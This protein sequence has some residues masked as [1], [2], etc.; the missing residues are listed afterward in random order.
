M[1]YLIHPRSAELTRELYNLTAPL[2]LQEPYQM[3]MRVF[4]LTVHEDQK[5]MNVNLDFPMFKHTEADVQAYLD[6]LTDPAPVKYF[7]EEA[8]WFTMQ[9]LLL[10][11][12][13]LRTFEELV[14]L[15]W[16]PNLTA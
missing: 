4:D 2:H 10:P 3:A 13:E 11:E 16:F 15:G 7:L 9:D 5:A 12:F 8:T 6:L 14:A 1:V